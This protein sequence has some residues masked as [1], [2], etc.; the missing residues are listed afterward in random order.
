MA[1]TLPQ[2]DAWGLEFGK[3]TCDI[4]YQQER[5]SLISKSLKQGSSSARVYTL[6][7]RACEALQDSA[8]NLSTKEWERA[9]RAAALPSPTSQ[10]SC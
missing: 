10:A 8:E 4:M 5:G 3:L 9:G 1:K 2:L 6:H 7:S